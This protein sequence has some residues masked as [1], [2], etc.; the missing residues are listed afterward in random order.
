MTLIKP[1]QCPPNCEITASSAMLTCCSDW[2]MCPD[3]ITC[4]TMA[5]WDVPRAEK[6]F[7]RTCSWATPLK[8]TGGCHA[9][10]RRPGDNE[11]R[12]PAESERAASDWERRKERGVTKQAF[13]SC[14]LQT[15]RWSSQ[16]AD[17]RTERRKEEEEEVLA[18]AVS[19][20]GA[21]N[22]SVRA[23]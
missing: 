21:P 9:G 14:T 20:A 11:K 2:R 7:C 13:H 12:K 18:V 16:P 8:P 17:W 23:S 1:W 4:L 19:G 15:V 10:P 22:E 3:C 5:W 6:L